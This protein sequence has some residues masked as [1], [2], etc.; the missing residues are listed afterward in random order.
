VPSGTNRRP[1]KPD[2]LTSD[3]DMIQRYREDPLIHG[4]ISFRFYTVVSQAGAWAIE[5]ADQLE[6]TLLLMHAS[7][8][9]VTSMPASKQF[10]ERAGASLCTFMEWPDFTHE[11]HNDRQRDR[12]LDVISQ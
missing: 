6:V 5:H 1:L 7:Q 9:K 3:P 12:V 8:D 11:L 4:D 2:H 10:A